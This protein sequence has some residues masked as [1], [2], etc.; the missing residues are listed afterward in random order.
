MRTTLALTLLLASAS[1]GVAHASTVC[2]T[3]TFAVYESQGS[4]TIGDLTF[5]QFELNSNIDATQVQVIPLSDGL[6]FIGPADMAPSPFFA[7]SASVTSS[8]EMID[9]ATINI[10]GSLTSV[11][12]HVCFVSG[13]STPL[14][15]SVNPNLPLTFDPVQ[16][17]QS[18]TF[19][20]GSG[21]G[22][23]SILIA[24][25]T[26][27]PEVGTMVGETIGLMGLAAYWILR[28]RYLWLASPAS[29]R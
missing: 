9:G 12:E 27:T 24:H 29:T 14:V 26:E 4:C 6:E 10:L 22:T 20:T 28:K 25:I 2:T 15:V 18:A 11:D 7:G 8:V 23:Q 1:A 21:A 16:Y 5:A 3:S 13:C 19:V 17:V